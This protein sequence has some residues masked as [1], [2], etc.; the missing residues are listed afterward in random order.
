MDHPALL[1]ALVR[2]HVL[3]DMTNIIR[4]PIRTG[5]QRVTHQVARHWPGDHPILPFII[6]GPDRIGLIEPTILEHVED[7][8]T[9]N[10][11]YIQKLQGLLNGKPPFHNEG[12]FRLRALG[13]RPLWEVPVVEAARHARAVLSLELSLNTDFYG[14][15]ARACPE[16]VFIVNYDYIVWLYP[17]FN[18]Q[19]DWRNQGHFS[20][21]LHILRQFPNQAFISSATRDDYRRRINR[22]DNRDYPVIVPGGDGL[23]R[24]SR[25]DIG[26]SPDFVV[27]G[28]LEPRKQPVRIIEAFETLHA[29]G[30]PA[31]L[32]FAGQMGW[33]T[34]TDRDYFERAIEHNPLIAWVDSP[35]DEELREI[36]ARARATI[37]F[38]EVEGFGAPPIEGLWLGVP[39][40]VSEAIPSIMDI[41]PHGQIRIGSRDVAA[42]R[43]AVLEFLDENFARAKQAEIADLD[44]P[45][46]Q[47]FILG[48]SSWIDH[49]AAISAAPGRPAAGRGFM[50][51]LEALRLFQQLSSLDDGELISRLFAI[52]LRREPTGEETAYWTGRL[53]AAG[54]TRREF[55]LSFVIRSGVEQVIGPG[56]LS[57]MVLSW[58][59]AGSP[60]PLL[61]RTVSQRLAD[62]LRLTGE[63]LD[64][65]DDAGFVDQSARRLLN[66]P[67]DAN[68]AADRLRDLAA[69]MLRTEVLRALID[70]EEYRAKNASGEQAELRLVADM[71]EL[72]GHYDDARFVDECFYRLLK[73]APDPEPA[74]EW[75]QRLA[76]GLSRSAVLQALINRDEYR[77]K[78]PSYHDERQLLG[79]LPDFHARACVA[80]M[81]RQ[82]DNAAFVR[83][84][85]VD[86]LRREPDHG[87]FVAHLSAINAGMQREEAVVRFLVS[88]EYL[89]KVTDIDSHCALLRRLLA[90]LPP[91]K[92]TAYGLDEEVS[93]DADGEAFSLRIEALL[94]TEQEQFLPQCFHTL[95]GRQPSREEDAYWQSRIARGAGRIN[96]IESLL[97]ERDVT[98]AAEHPAGSPKTSE[99]LRFYRN[100]AAVDELLATE[101]PAEFVRGCYLRLLGRPPDPNGFERYL[102]DLS[103]RRSRV[104]CI[105]SFLSSAEYRHRSVGNTARYEQLVDYVVSLER[106]LNGTSV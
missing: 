44:L 35:P 75:R 105:A 82:P 24:G 93:K 104:D 68:S 9:A 58:A 97:A 43:A 13:L 65:P 63:L 40:I 4:Y 52:L 60:L 48:I 89:S 56:L 98:A 54:M 86:L 31:R 26:R 101:D 30:H 100:L 79:M 83:A 61:D 1:K 78:S 10:D 11:D 69:G 23:G 28:T 15:L 37:C 92:L 99:M 41:A 71:E 32:I 19:I 87:G 106:G 57:C 33:L 66:R 20:E 38:A 2:D 72:L 29:E 16:K 70:C 77:Q 47:E 59:D 94:F 91:E 34:K 46:W 25:D 85:Y 8:F 81:L 7:Y 45:T 74:A 80:R 18:D 102:H 3:F 50:E 55:V 62:L 5:I 90:R 21:Y 36:V 103:Q 12:Y 67:L 27:V 84:L 14:T 73:R 76:E 22:G 17:R 39:A 6:T 64:Q 51:R 49:T 88:H 95:R 96:V 42:L 53:P